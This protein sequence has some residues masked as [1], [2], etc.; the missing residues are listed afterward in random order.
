[1]A[2]AVA[3]KQRALESREIALDSILNTHYRSNLKI[4]LGKN[5]T[6]YHI[7]GQ[8]ERPTNALYGKFILLFTTSQGAISIDLIE[9]Y[10]PSSAFKGREIALG[11]SRYEI[12]YVPQNIAKDPFIGELMILALEPGS[13]SY[14]LHAGEILRGLYA[15]ALQ[16]PAAKSRIAVYTKHGSINEMWVLIMT[17]TPPERYAEFR[18]LHVDAAAIP[19]NPASPPAQLGSVDFDG[20]RYYLAFTKKDGRRHLWVQ[21]DAP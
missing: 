4:E 9:I 13:A 15:T 17:E 1:M 10:R 19:D 14:K 7:S 8:E 11:G 12:K 6:M 16:L 20:H 21:T 5:K 3:L 18:R 2:G